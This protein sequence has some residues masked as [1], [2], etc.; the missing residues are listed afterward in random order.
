LELTW[1]S[2]NKHKQTE[3]F[4]GMESIKSFFVSQKGGFLGSLLTF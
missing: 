3:L 2:H 4:N 1:L